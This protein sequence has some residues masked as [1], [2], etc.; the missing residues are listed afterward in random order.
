[1][2]EMPESLNYQM[3]NKGMS[4]LRD[5][6]STQPSVADIYT[7][8][9]TFK[10]RGDGYAKE[11]QKFIMQNLAHFPEYYTVVDGIAAILPDN[12]ESTTPLYLGDENDFA[13]DDYSLRK[14][15]G[16]NPNRINPFYWQ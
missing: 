7:M 13:P 5:D 6:K 4:T 16:N 2:A 8:I 12:A 9:A 3:Y 1:M 14:E 10:G 15:R 11:M